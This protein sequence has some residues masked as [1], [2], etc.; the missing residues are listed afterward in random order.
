MAVS[1]VFTFNMN[2]NQIIESALRRIGVLGALDTPDASM[3]VDSQERLNLLLKSWHAEKLGIWILS[4]AT[5]FLELD[6][7]VYTIGSS[8]GD[9]ITPSFVETALSADAV[10]TDT[11]ISVD[12]ISGISDDYNIGIVLDD[13]SLFWTQVNGTPSGDTIVLD[14]GLDGDTSE[15]KAVYAYASKSTKILSVVEARYVNGDTDRVINIISRGEY[16]AVSPKESTGE[17]VM[18]YYQPRISDGLLYVWPVAAATNH[19][20][21]MTVKTEFDDVIALSNNVR[22]PTEWL[23]CIIDNLAVELL[24][25]YKSKFTDSHQL[26]IANANRKLRQMKRHDSPKVPFKIRP[27]LR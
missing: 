24:P 5:L 6:K 15:A 16:M 23:D 11:S 26:L 3:I 14:D 17:V 1:G 12:S 2:R 10:E 22:F 4:E 21:K 27:R 9:H 7:Q 19:Q 20:I 18:I 25:E 8:T 13:N